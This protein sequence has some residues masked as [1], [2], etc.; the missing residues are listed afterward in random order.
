MIK[1]I[2]LAGG[3]FWGFEEL[4]RSQGG[5]IDTKVGYTGGDR[6]ESNVS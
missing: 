1:K 6:G 5:V 2:V 3:C 4:I